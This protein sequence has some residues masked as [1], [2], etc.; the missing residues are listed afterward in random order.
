[1]RTNGHYTAVIRS[2]KKFAVLIE[3][4]PKLPFEAFTLMIE[5]YLIKIAKF[6]IIFERVIKDDLEIDGV[7]FWLGSSNRKIVY[8]ALV[9]CHKHEK[10]KFIEKLKAWELNQ[11]KTT[12]KEITHS[13]ILKRHF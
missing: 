2:L 13:R 9:V 8:H 3:K 7:D 10:E 5:Y 4:H 12:T 1:M 11:T 6:I